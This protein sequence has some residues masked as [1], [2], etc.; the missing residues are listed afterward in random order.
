MTPKF[1]PTHQNS[2]KIRK[3]N[4]NRINKYIK[5]MQKTR[6]MAALWVLCLE[7]FPHIKTTSSPNIINST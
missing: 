3:Y 5:S 6:I 2:H 4:I 7:W 1:H